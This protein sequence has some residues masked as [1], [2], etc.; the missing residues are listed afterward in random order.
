MYGTVVTI[1]LCLARS[2]N[3]VFTVIQYDAVLHNVVLYHVWWSSHRTYSILDE[4]TGSH[5]VCLHV[6]SCWLVSEPQQRWANEICGSLM[7]S[8]LSQFRSFTCSVL[9]FT[10]GSRG[11][12]ASYYSS[13]LHSLASSLVSLCVNTRLG[14]NAGELCGETSARQ[15]ETRWSSSV[16][17]ADQRKHP[18]RHFLYLH[19]SVCSS[20][21]HHLHIYSLLLGRGGG[22]LP[23]AGFASFQ[24]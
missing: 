17:A 24:F 3:H 21:L 8:R 5:N 13:V 14:V 12:R 6:A 22:A 16:S 20:P 9:C 15:R 2:L 4:P 11:M 1:I 19:T 23:E 10:G 7:K 18:D